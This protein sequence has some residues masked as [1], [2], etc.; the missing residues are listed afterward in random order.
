[1]SKL[2]L[3][4]SNVFLLHPYCSDFVEKLLNSPDE[5]A[6]D[7]ISD[8]STA[9]IVS[10]EIGPDHILRYT[11]LTG[12]GLIVYPPPNA[13]WHYMIGKTY[14]TP[15]IKAPAHVSFI[16]RVMPHRKAYSMKGLVTQIKLLSR[17]TF[18][19]HETVFPNS[20]TSE[21]SSSHEAN[22]DNKL[23]EQCLEGV[24]L[25][26]PHC[27]KWPHYNNSGKGGLIFQL[28]FLRKTA[29]KTVGKPVG[30]ESCTL[31]NSKDWFLTSYSPWPMKRAKLTCMYI[32]SEPIVGQPE[33]EE[34]VK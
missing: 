5:L 9:V 10:K 32:Q 11:H 31:Q 14:D 19:Y 6:Q 26:G 34:I 21:F 2:S 12:A 25:L 30:L 23:V 4:W 17:S 28:D 8:G 13:Q 27:E 29:G 16:A 3:I 33:V 24:Q 1:M 20:F 15:V 18:P 22:F 7:I